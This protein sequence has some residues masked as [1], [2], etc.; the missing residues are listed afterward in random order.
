MTKLSTQAGELDGLAPLMSTPKGLYKHYKGMLYEV[1]DTVRHSETLEP[2]TLYRALYGDF[3][4]W[5]R[6][7]AMFNETVV[8]DG[9]EQARFTPLSARPAL[10]FTPPFGWMND[11]NGLVFFDGEYHLF[12][13]CYPGG[14]AIGDRFN[15]PLKWGPMHWG[16]AVSR[17]LVHWEHSPVAITPLERLEN[18]EVIGMAFSGC[19]VIDWDNTAGFNHGNQPAM[20]A[21]YTQCD[22]IPMGNQRQG[23]AYSRDR[24]RTWQQYAGNPVLRNPD[25]VDFRDPKVFWHKASRAWVMAL[26]AK[27]QILFYRSRDLKQWDYLSSFGSDPGPGQGARGEPW[28]CPDLFELPVKAGTKAFDSSQQTAA[29]ASRWVLLVSV[30]KNA[31]NGGSGTQY[32]IG[33]FD[34]TRFVNDNP[35]DCILWLDYGRD[36]YAAVTWEGHP[37]NASERI[38]LGWMSNWDYAQD[39][40]AVDYR[41]AM[42]VARRLSLSSTEQGLRLTSLPVEQVSHQFKSIAEVEVCDQLISIKQLNE[43]INQQFNKTIN[44]RFNQQREVLRLKTYQ[45]EIQ[46]EVSASL[47]FGFKVCKDDQY[48]MIVGFDAGSKCVYIDRSNSS[49]FKFAGDTKRRHEAPLQALNHQLSL[50]ILVDQTSVEVFADGGQICLTDLHL[51]PDTA[52]GIELFANVDSIVIKHLQIRTLKP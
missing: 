9:I 35:D 50:R 1:V 22:T 8:I 20:I 48:Q 11:P 38:V 39:V 49:A 40:P 15:D 52:T 23:L 51:A 37:K 44:Q 31:A 14:F 42:A 18:G 25:R 27:D 12:Y 33:H 3:G 45:I 16:H 5:V 26:A 36:F 29:T 30:A 13:Q 41:S 6:P 10:H 17:D 4:L 47:E 28:E 43:T 21:V 46:F 24:G 34:G 32:F 19:V 7:A 2:M